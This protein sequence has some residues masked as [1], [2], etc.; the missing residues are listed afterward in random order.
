MVT[1][2]ADVYSTQ[3]VAGAPRPDRLEPHTPLHGRE[4]SSAHRARPPPGHV[5]GPVFRRAQDRCDRAQRSR[6]HAPEVASDTFSIDWQRRVNFGAGTYVF[7][8]EVDDG[9]RL[10][11]DGTPL[12]DAYTAAGSRVVTATR[13]LA[14]GPHDLQVQYVEYSGQSRFRL[15]WDLAAP[16]PTPLP[17]PSAVPLPLPPTSTPVPPSATPP[18][19]SATLPPAATD[20]PAPTWPPP[21]PLP[22]TDTVTPM[23]IL[24]MPTTTPE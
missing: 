3:R 17:P 20:T 13:V 8:A 22:P 5:A 4:R 12:I 11:L 6:T 2:R 19:P 18:P 23:A 16:T 24:I 14:A 15:G 10:Y 9:V 1:F 21:P 7:T